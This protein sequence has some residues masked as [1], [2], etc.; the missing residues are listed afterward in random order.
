MN[1]S[2]CRQ[3]VLARNFVH[4]KG[5]LG[6]LAGLI[7]ANR[8]SNQQRNLW[9]LDLLDIQPD[10][11]ILEFGCGP[12]WALNQACQRASR[13]HVVG[14]DPS[15]VM[16]RQATRRNQ[17][18]ITAGQLR[19]VVADAENLPADL[20]GPFDRIFS[21]NVFGFLDDPEN[22]FRRLRSHLGLNGTIA[23]TWLPRL[24]SKSD[25]AAVGMADRIAKV[26]SHAGWEVLRTEFRRFDGVI[27]CCV[28]AGSA[29]NDPNRTTDDIRSPR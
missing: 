26:C 22:T 18:A 27:A 9:T 17:K 19:L 1:L 11:R 12:G 24:G 21:S 29:H 28:I 25:D 13:G 4:P 5:L 3:N 14:I 6:W 8:A 7:M 20:G 23:T 2:T 16:L 10:H 15:Q